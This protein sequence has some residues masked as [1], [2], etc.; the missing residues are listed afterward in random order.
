MR[1]KPDNRARARSAK[2]ISGALSA[3]TPCDIVFQTIA[4]DCLAELQ[5]CSEGAKHGNADAVHRMR[6]S[7]TRLQTAIRFFSPVL[8]RRWTVHCH[9][10]L[11]GLRKLL[12]SARDADIAIE[13]GHPKG[14]RQKLWQN[15]RQRKYHELRRVI[16]SKTYKGLV[17]TF[18]RP[19]AT[20]HTSRTSAFSGAVSFSRFASER[21]DA[22]K[23]KLLR[24]S[25]GLKT[26]GLHKIHRVRVKS[27]RLRY[28]LEWSLSIATGQE[29]RNM[30]KVLKSVN[31]IQRDLGDLADA[32]THRDYAKPKDW[33]LSQG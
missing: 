2:K 30:K 20:K 12:G 28:A 13:R 9:R 6:V 18:T 11:V 1:R 14:E 26:L 17:A 22:W 4:A 21:L 32:R 31:R 27:K 24:S 8:D 25:R 19:T 7:L 16:G 23:Q 5:S 29:F 10:A 33:C 3:A 15:V